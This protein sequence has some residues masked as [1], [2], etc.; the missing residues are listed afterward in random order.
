MFYRDF[1]LI[2]NFKLKQHL[3][4]ETIREKFKNKR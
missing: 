4:K 2:L 3:K 1:G